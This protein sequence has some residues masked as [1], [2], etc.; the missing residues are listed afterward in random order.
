VS[1]V[2]VSMDPSSPNAATGP[3][4]IERAPQPYIC[5]PRTV[6]MATLPSAADE[7]PGLLAWL[8]THGTEPAGPPFI[9]YN[10][11][12]MARELQVEAG[13]PVAA[14]VAGDGQVRAGTLPGG[15][16]AAVTHVGPYDQLVPAVRRLLDWAQGQGL[17]WDK[18]DSPEGQRWGCRLEIYPV[19]PAEQPDPAKWETELVFRLAG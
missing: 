2:W 10:V 16:Y 4:V 3:S 14:P 9:K 17:T 8:A 7:I 12:D 13:V 1:V 6:T 11:I 15:R 18:Q 19:N 5:V